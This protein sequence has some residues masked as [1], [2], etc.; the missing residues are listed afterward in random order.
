MAANMGAESLRHAELVAG[1]SERRGKV[2]RPVIHVEPRGDRVTVTWAE[3]L[4][5]GLLREYRRKHGVP[6]AELQAFIDA[7]RSLYR[8]PY[9]LA[10]RRP[11]VS[12]ASSCPRR[13]MSPD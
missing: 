4:E 3:F 6:I 11:F 9:P 12:A 10:D 5:A 2:Y 13:K 7:V 1:R 8:V